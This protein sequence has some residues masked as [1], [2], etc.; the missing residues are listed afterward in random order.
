MPPE[1]PWTFFGF[2]YQLAEWQGCHQPL[3][4]SQARSSIRGHLVGAHTLTAR[5]KGHGKGV[6]HLVSR[7]AR[8]A[9]RRRAQLRQHPSSS[10]DDVYLAGRV[11]GCGKSL[12]GHSP[13]L[14]GAWART[15][16]WTG[17]TG[18]SH[19]ASERLVQRDPVAG[20]RPSL[21]RHALLLNPECWHGLFRELTHEVFCHGATQLWTLVPHI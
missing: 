10:D 1:P 18:R 17:R 12:K 5:N 16:A 11:P 7:G 14:T 20:R 15:K 3:T 21:A 19:Q 2:R 4:N 13:R 8:L 6:E 9:V